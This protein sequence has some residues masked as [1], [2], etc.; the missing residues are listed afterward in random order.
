MGFLWVSIWRHTYSVTDPFGT[1]T[2]GSQN[3]VLWPGPATVPGAHNDHPDRGPMAP[4]TASDTACHDRTLTLPSRS[5]QGTP[6]S[7]VHHISFP[8]PGRRAG[9]VY[10]CRSTEVPE[11]GLVANEWLPSFTMVTRDVRTNAEA[12]G[13]PEGASHRSRSADGKGPSASVWRP[14]GSLRDGGEI[15]PL[16]RPGATS[17]V[18]LQ[19]AQMD[20]TRCL[21]ERRRMKG[22]FVTQWCAVRGHRGA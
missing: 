16:Q 17:C 18:P 12:R 2:A 8:V 19:S 5:G 14:Y 4:P 20:A 9:H 11:D 15:G 10:A 3:P 21:G 22:T 13:S 7:W 1:D 6:W